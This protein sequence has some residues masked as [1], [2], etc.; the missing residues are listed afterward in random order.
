MP[1]TVPSASTVTAV[2]CYRPRARFSKIDPITTT[3]LSRAASASASVVG[4]GTASAR[5]K[6]L[7]SSR[8]QKYCALKSSGRHTTFAPI[9]A[10]SDLRHRPRQVLLR[11][12]AALHLDQ[13]HVVVFNRQA[14]PRK[15]RNEFLG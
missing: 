1:F 4:P 13:S 9:F 11:L 15:E 3:L 2:L 12:R 8:W 14:F 5:S 6:S 7:A 10:A